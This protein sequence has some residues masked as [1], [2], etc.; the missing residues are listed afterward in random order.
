MTGRR[1]T[2]VSRCFR[3]LV[4]RDESYSFNFLIACREDT[5][6]EYFSQ[7]GSVEQV[8]ILKDKHT[9]RSRGFAFVQFQLTQAAQ[10]ALMSK[11]H[12]IDGKNCDVKVA[13]PKVGALLFRVFGRTS[14]VCR[15]LFT[16]FLSSCDPVHRRLRS[17]CWNFN[18]PS[19]PHSA[20]TNVYHTVPYE[21]C[22]GRVLSSNFL[23]YSANLDLWYFIG[24]V[25]ECLPAAATPRAG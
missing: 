8:E 9:Q 16:L 19:T 4:H 6:R 5:L 1:I 7:F 22:L 25:V 17:A 14:R 13:H 24:I 2:Y 20:E 18:A 11:S 21:S 23:H 3:K 12:K 10:E 15:R